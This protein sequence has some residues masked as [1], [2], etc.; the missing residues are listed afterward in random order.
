MS[1]SAAITGVGCVSGFGVGAAATWQGLLSARQAATTQVPHEDGC[2]SSCV[3]A[4][5]AEVMSKAVPSTSFGRP[6]R[7][8][9]MAKLAAEEAWTSAAL[10]TNADPDRTGLIV[11]RNFGQHEVI[12]EYYRTLWD[13]G[14]S[15]VSGL[16]FVQTVAN[17]VLGQIALQ[18]CCRGPSL[19][20]Y[21]A[22]ALTLALDAIRDDV[23]DVVLVGAFDELSAY[24]VELCHR[25]QVV[26]ENR[27]TKRI[28][29]PY[30]RSSEGLLPGEAAVFLVL[31]RPEFCNA[32]GVS[33]I[34]YIRGYGEVSDHRYLRNPAERDQ[35]ET[36]IALR[37]AL[38]D[39]DISAGD[40]T[41]ISGA[42]NGVAQADQAELCCI[43]TVFRCPPLLFSVK[44]ALGETWGAAAALST[45]AAMRC[46]RD[47]I[48]PPTA[49][50]PDNHKTE[51][52]PVVIGS[53]RQ[54]FAR[55]AVVNSFEMAGQNCC[56]I[57][58]NEP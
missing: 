11:G 54:V 18:Y 49:G 58:A 12:G 19:L 15:A 20:L 7:V 32:R 1:R 38:L 33:A 53:A 9:L 48:A 31:E 2:Q 44:G 55:T 40:V 45:L 17:S 25:R 24:V 52:I 57:L 28:G 10:G 39:A 56:Y 43:A 26:H 46:L 27:R 21:G 23:A 34:A 8:G 5:S 29:R 41:V 50:A 4:P 14:P 22:S 42:G 36:S 35:R 6:T 51:N 37:N 16:Q 3:K 13:K 47:N 30:D